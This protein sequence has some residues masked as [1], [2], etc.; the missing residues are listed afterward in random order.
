MKKNVLFMTTF[1]L[2]CLTFLTHYFLTFF[3]QGRAFLGTTMVI[4]LLSVILIQKIFARLPVLSTFSFTKPTWP[5]LPASIIIPFSLGLLLHSYFYFTHHDSFL[6]K[7][8]SQLIM[9][10]LI[11][12]TISTGSALLEEIVWRGNFHVYLRQHYSFWSTAFLIGILWSFWHLPIALL[13]KSYIMPTV[14]IP[15]YLLLLFVLS[16]MLSIIRECGQSIVPVAIFHGMMNVFYLSDGHDMTIS[17]D[18]QELVKCL[19][20]IVFFF[21]F[22]HRNVTILKK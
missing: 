4:P 17:P 16:L 12:L 21:L 14:G 6:I 5:W 1:F 11:G 19:M 10:L 18:N 13:Y 22:C 8:P 2:Y 9:L 3:E 15:A 20:L 7:T